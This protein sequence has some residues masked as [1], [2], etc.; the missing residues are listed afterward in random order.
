MTDDEVALLR[1]VHSQQQE[2]LKRVT[3]VEGLLGPLTPEHVNSLVRFAQLVAGM[4]VAQ[5]VIIAICGIIVAIAGA[6][7][8]LKGWFPFQG[9]GNGAS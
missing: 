4:G 9:G 3:A 1:S 7:A 2:I 6:I 5:K 8:A